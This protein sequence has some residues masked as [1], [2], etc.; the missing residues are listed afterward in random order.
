MA[1][2]HT[3]SQESRA[4]AGKPRDAVV[5]SRAIVAKKLRSYG[6]VWKS[7]AAYYSRCGNFGRS[8]VC[9]IGL[10]YSPD[11]TPTLWF[12]RWEV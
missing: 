10:I 7:R 3:P 2:I 8:L 12:K 6:V 5:R 4:A 1:S 9:N 11:G